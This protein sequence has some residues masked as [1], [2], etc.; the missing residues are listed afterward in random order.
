MTAS[1]SFA[2]S[3]RE[4]KKPKRFFLGVSYNF[5]V[6]ADEN[7]KK[8]YGSRNFYPNLKAG[9]F[10]SQELYLWGGYGFVS[11]EGEIDIY[12]TKMEAK[13]KQSFFSFGAGYCGSLS[14]KLDYRIE[15][16]GVSFRYEEEAME[17]TDSESSSGFK[18]NLGICWNFSRLFFADL[19]A[20]YM[21]GSKNLGERTV[22][23]GGF[24][25]GLGFGIGF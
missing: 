24:T 5:L 2:L 20:G 13:S 9:F 23:I 19:F 17:K 18:L 6:P 12:G 15:A 21:Y 16:G 11:G 22:K 7:F 1:V 4:V 3:D 25:A 8:I 14:G 10:I